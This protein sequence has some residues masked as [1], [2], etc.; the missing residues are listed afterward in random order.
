[1][2][3]M[4]PVFL[5]LGVIWVSVPLAISAVIL[6]PRAYKNLK[7]KSW[8]LAAEIRRCSNL[9]PINR[10]VLYVGSLTFMVSSLSQ[11]FL[12]GD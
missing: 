1:M 12:G 4:Q 9:T 7:I 6:Y 10:F 3:I 11:F 2:A 5:A 8:R